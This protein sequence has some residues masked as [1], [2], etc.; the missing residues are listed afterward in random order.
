MLLL[1][2]Q[3]P[4]QKA[5][6]LLCFRYACAGCFCYLPFIDAADVCELY[7]VSSAG[8][9]RLR[10]V[11]REWEIWPVDGICIMYDTDKLLL[12]RGRAG[13]SVHLWSVWIQARE[14]DI[15]VGHDQVVLVQVL[16]GSSWLP[17]FSVLSCACIFCD[18][19]R[20]YRTRG[21]V[22]AGASCP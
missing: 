14:R 17:S 4:F 20:A 13:S 6:K 19:G 2:W 15:G 1:A 12:C 11:L 8:A 21:T 5:G 7:A 3:R 22:S 18:V 10:P 16:P 9:D